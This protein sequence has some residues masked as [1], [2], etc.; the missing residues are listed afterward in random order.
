[1]SKKVYVFNLQQLINEFFFQLVKKLIIRKILRTVA[2]CWCITIHY[3]L[4]LKIQPEVNKM[5]TIL[6]LIQTGFLRSR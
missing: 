6:S 3:E 2:V 5:R 4:L 1:L